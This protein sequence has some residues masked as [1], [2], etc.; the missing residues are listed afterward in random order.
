LFMDDYPVFNP[1][2][3][4]LQQTIW[5]IDEILYRSAQEFPFSSPSKTISGFF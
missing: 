3:F 2:G 1:G 4:G 5:D